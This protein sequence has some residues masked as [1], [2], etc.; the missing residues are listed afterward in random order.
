MAGC[1]DSGEDAPKEVPPVPTDSAKSVSELVVRVTL[2]GIEPAIWRDLFLPG[3]A[4]FLDLH[5]AIQAAF[6][7][8]N[9]HL[10]LFEVGT[11]RISDPRFELDV[12]F[13][14]ERRVL[15]TS[16]LTTAGSRLRYEYDFGDGWRHD[17]VVR[18]VEAVYPGRAKRRMRCV[19]GARACPPDDCGGTPGYEG[20]LEALRDP[21]HEQHAELSGWLSS[22][23]RGLSGYDRRFRGPFDPEAFDVAA[24]NRAVSALEL[25]FGLPEPD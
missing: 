18:E 17:V 3:S 11:R 2:E 6:P 25:G 21:A 7:W 20:L 12:P 22:Y 24:A 4:S 16:A 14:D 19:G 1:G 5:A 15:V 13:Q 8:T 10:H 9:S 23:R